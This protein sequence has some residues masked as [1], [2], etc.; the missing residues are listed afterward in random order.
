MNPTF[1]QSGTSLDDYKFSFEYYLDYSNSIQADS[2]YDFHKENGRTYH[3]YRAGA[4]HHPNDATEVERLDD[5]YQILKIILD[6][7][8]YLAPFSR[9]KPPHKVL[10]IATG[11]GSWAI[12][13]GDEFP[14]AQIIG[15]DLSP[16]QSDLV[17]PNV[18]FVIDDATDEWPGGNDWCNFDF[19]HTRVTIGCWSD[20]LTQV[21]RPAFERL[22][23]GGWMESQELMGI[24]EC[25]N[26]PI[27][28]NNAFKMWVDDIVE[29]CIE[30]DRPMTFAASLKKWY[31]DAGFINV[32]EKVYK[33]PINGW[34]RIRKLKMLGQLWHAN[35]SNGLAAFSYALL[36]R[37]K[38]MSQ[39]EIE[40]SLLD[41]R[42]DLA[43][44][45]VQIYESFYVVYGQ[46][47]EGDSSSTPQPQLFDTI[48][49]G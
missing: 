44:E 47:P 43:D 48:M 29:A 1:N 35:L 49:A 6:G 14:E 41:V 38:G 40:I 24:L 17:P 7:R 19:I 30:V 27:P 2:I 15:T 36:H 25:D 8:N 23:P 39:E 3:A 31:M 20:M 18:Q 46:K 28:E 34:P 5:Q 9:E 16:I 37:T 26:G 21:I 42:R 32:H 33:I 45:R 10:D 13:L 12:D 4:Y 22:R 11:S